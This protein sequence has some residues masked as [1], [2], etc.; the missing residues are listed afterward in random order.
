MTTEANGKEPKPTEDRLSTVLAQL[1]TAQMRFVIARGEYS[2]DREAAEAIDFS[3]S[4]IKGWKVKGAPIDEAVRL[5]AFDGIVIAS[6]LRRRN[7]AKAMAVKVGGLDNESDIIAQRVAT[8]IIEGEMGKPTQRTET[9]TEG[10]VGLT[11]RY[12]NDWRGSPANAPQGA[13]G[14]QD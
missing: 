11:V 5:M 13:E 9:K 2:T 14:S 4:T 8:E 6:E 7:L 1:T 10:E 3:P 12:V